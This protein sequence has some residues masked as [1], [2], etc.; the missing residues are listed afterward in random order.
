[1]L[2]PGHTLS[3]VLG[4]EKETQETAIHAFVVL[5]VNISEVKETVC[6]VRKV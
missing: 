1:M 2:T 5:A 6:Q 3:W 4:T